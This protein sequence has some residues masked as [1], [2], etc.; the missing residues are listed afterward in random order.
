[1][2]L[3]NILKCK[4]LNSNRESSTNSANFYEEI[5]TII[6]PIGIV[7]A[8]KFLSTSSVQILLLEFSNREFNRNNVTFS[9]NNNSNKNC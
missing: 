9:E 4:K 1:M 7:I 3:S 6:I 8:S 2:L 5:Q